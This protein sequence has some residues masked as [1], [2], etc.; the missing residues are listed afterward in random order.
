MKFFKLALT[1][2]SII[3]VL[4]VFGCDNKEKIR[5]KNIEKGIE[6]VALDVDKL[7]PEPLK[8][9]IQSGVIS[10][11]QAKSELVALYSGA[12]KKMEDNVQKCKKI[13]DDETNSAM[14]GHMI[15]Y[16]GVP[17]M[18]IGADRQKIELYQREM[19]KYGNAAA[20][21]GQVATQIGAFDTSIK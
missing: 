4:G 15:M 16:N 10:P 13:I 6:L 8:M 2:I 9:K 11:D 18:A 7:A 1:T 19:Q 21:F 3:A 12:A 20:H 5:L 14:S 17:T